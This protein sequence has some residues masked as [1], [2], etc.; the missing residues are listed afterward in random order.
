MFKNRYKEYLIC[1]IGLYG[2]ELYTKH[3]WLGKLYVYL[4][5][6][7]V[8]AIIQCNDILI[9]PLLR[10]QSAR[11]TVEHN[12]PNLRNSQTYASQLN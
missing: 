10:F 7:Q 2:E 11:P 1:I 9:P 6:R 8:L 5:K 3:T 12:Q 4:L